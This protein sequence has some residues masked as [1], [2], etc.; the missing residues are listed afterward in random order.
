[1]KNCSPNLL[2]KDQENPSP[3]SNHPSITPA[4]IVPTIL[5]SKLFYSTIIKYNFKI[6]NLPYKITSLS[7]GFLFHFSGDFLIESLQ[8]GYL[9]NAIHA[10]T[11]KKL[12]KQFDK[13][14]NIQTNKFKLMVIE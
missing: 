14:K 6:D 5:Q 7:K 11:T 9:C 8:K 12:V 10:T 1:M 2:F 13:R 4:K 3:P